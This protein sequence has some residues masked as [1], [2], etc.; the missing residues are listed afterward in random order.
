MY[1]RVAGDA[2]GLSWVSRASACA[3]RSC[4]VFILRLDRF[5]L[6]GWEC[7]PDDSQLLVGHHFLFL[8]LPLLLL[9]LPFPGHYWWS[10]EPLLAPGRAAGAPTAPSFPPSLLSPLL[11]SSHPFFGSFILPLVLPS[12][13]ASILPSFLTFIVVLRNNVSHRGDGLDVDV[14]VGGGGDHD[15]LGEGPPPVIGRRGPL[16]ERLG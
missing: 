8:L 2:N 6:S 12:F 14:R 7:H 9:I 15:V 1:G 13:H 11:P 5:P 10:L 16:D 3:N 4:Q